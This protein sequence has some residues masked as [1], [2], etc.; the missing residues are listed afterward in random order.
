MNSNNE[1]WEILFYFILKILII[2]SLTGIYYFLTIHQKGVGCDQIVRLYF[3]L[4]LQSS[5]PTLLYSTVQCCSHTSTFF[6]GHLFLI[7]TI[8]CVIPLSIPIKY[9]AIIIEQCQ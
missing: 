5:T 6:A 1:C 7:N 9:V 2:S 3:T 8:L 4:P